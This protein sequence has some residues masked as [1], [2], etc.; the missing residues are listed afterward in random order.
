MLSLDYVVGFCTAVA[1]ARVTGAGAEA[2][3]TS[4]VEVELGTLALRQLTA[5]YYFGCTTPHPELDGWRWSG[6]EWP[7]VV[8]AELNG[9]ALH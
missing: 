2:A 4:A 3:T 7:L 1:V 6:P 5:V 9:S 8:T